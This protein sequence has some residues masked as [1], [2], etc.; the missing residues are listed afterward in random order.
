M[1]ISQGRH[2]KQLYGIK[3]HISNSQKLFL[4]K[5]KYW[6][7]ISQELKTETNHLERNLFKRSSVIAPT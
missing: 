2:H 1:Y 6:V 5:R 4:I 3:V 7:G